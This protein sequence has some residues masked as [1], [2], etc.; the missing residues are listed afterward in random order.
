MEVE[1]TSQKPPPVIKRKLPSHQRPRKRR[2]VSKKE[3]DDTLEDD[4][5]EDDHFSL[6]PV[7]M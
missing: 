4:S 3:V 6:K 7:L 2:R 5:P 1:P